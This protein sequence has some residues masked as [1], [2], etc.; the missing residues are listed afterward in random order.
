MK[1]SNHQK[2]QGLSSI[3]RLPEIFDRDIGEKLSDQ[4]HESYVSKLAACRQFV[5]RHFQKNYGIPA[6]PVCDMLLALQVS[7]MRT[8][9]IESMATEL[10]M[11]PKVLQRYLAIAEKHGLITVNVNAGIP[12]VS[13]AAKGVDD[14]LLITNAISE[15]AFK[16]RPLDSTN[17]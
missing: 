4:A 11:P 10:A 5:E 6:Y 7:D 14:L 2:Q 15:V 9:S 1:N 3:V 8:V 13:L 12:E 17:R 16:L